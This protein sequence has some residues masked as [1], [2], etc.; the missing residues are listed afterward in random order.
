MYQMDELID[1]AFA[2]ESRT[3]ADMVAAP[4]PGPSEQDKRRSLIQHN[5]R[6]VRSY[7]AAGV[8]EPLVLNLNGLPAGRVTRF[9]ARLE[10][11]GFNVSVENGILTANP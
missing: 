11:K 6:R 10:E 2:Q 4:D 3:A 5:M 7:L 8:N 9:Q 1:N